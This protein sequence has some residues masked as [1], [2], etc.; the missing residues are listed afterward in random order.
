[1]ESAR[2]SE[3]AMERDRE[4]GRVIYKPER[5]CQRY[6]APPPASL[7][8]EW[9]VAEREGERVRTLSEISSS[10]LVPQE[11]GVESYPVEEA[12]EG[13]HDGGVEV[14]RVE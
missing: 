10:H 5:R 4:K 9:S 13:S 6:L 2:D 8:P 11:V 3:R 12:G 7:H 14:L 1:M